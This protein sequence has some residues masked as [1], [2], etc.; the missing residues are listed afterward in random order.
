[1]DNPSGP[2]RPRQ[3][4]LSAWLIMVGSVLVVVMVF[5]RMAGLHSLETRESVQ[6][7]LSE[8]PGDDLGM[9]V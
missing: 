4:T 9:G 6:K 5:D 7:F 1:M 2:P 3:V 8:P